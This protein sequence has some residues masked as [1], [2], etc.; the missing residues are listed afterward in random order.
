MNRPIQFFRD[1]FG[2]DIRIH[3]SSKEVVLSRR[4]PVAAGFGHQLLFP[5]RLQLSLR[6]PQI[7]ALQ[8]YLSAHEISRSPAAPCRGPALVE[9]RERSLI[10]L[11][12]LPGGLRRTGQDDAQVFSALADT[13]CAA[14]QSHS[15]RGGGLSGCS[16]NPQLIIILDGP[17]ALADHVPVAGLEIIQSIGIGRIV[18]AGGVGHERVFLR[19]KILVDP[20]YGANRQQGP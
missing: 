16:K 7:L 10:P 13:G 2:A 11:R 18:D 14:L 12:H 17:W 20:D 1:Y 6:R 9:A 3:H 4:P 5:L 8:T 15:N 19:P